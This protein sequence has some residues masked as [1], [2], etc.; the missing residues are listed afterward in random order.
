MNIY[1]GVEYNDF[2][3]IVDALDASL[4]LD[5]VFYVDDGTNVIQAWAIL[6]SGNG[7]SIGVSSGVFSTDI[8][9]ATFTTDFAS[10]VSVSRSSIK[11][12]D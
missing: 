9:I 6:N 4:T 8:T 10:A 3:A 2:E 11:I 12:G 5:A 1:S 7:G